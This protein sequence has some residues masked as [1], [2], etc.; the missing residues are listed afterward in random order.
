MFADF[1]VGKK[2]SYSSCLLP[3]AFCLLPSTAYF[4]KTLIND[5]PKIYQ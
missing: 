2:N 4:F 3:S 1:F 5:I